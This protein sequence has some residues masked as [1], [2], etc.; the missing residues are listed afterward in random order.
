MSEN[1]NAPQ[2]QG[3]REAAAG[4]AGTAYSDD[5]ISLV[6]LW[7]TLVKRRN[8]IAV[9]VVGALALAVTLVIVRPDSYVYS[10]TLEIGHYPSEAADRDLASLD[11]VENALSKLLDGYIPEALRRYFV[12]EEDQS[13]LRVTARNPRGS[14][15]LVI[16]VKGTEDEGESLL[17][18]LRYVSEQL[19]DDHRYLLTI[20]RQQLDAR[21]E[22]ARLELAKYEDERIYR[23]QEQERV[24]AIEIAKLELSELVQ[25]QALVESRVKRLDNVQKLLEQQIAEIRESINIATENRRDA[26]QRVND[27]SAAMT[28]LMID[29]DIQQNRNR[30]ATLDERLHIGLPN[31][32]D[33]L[34]KRLDDILRAQSNMNAEIVARQFELE[35]F[36]IDWER[37][38]E[39]QRQTVRALEARLESARDTRVVT[40][41][42]RSLEPEGPGKAV[43]L[44][45]GV[46]LG[47]MIGI[48]AAFFAEFLKNARTSD[49]A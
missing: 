17:R 14:N 12:E 28:L 18:V 13:R 31:E 33:E 47:L 38:R 35:R 25:Q 45:L 1:Q 42:A 34:Q 6:D 11:S 21:L 20:K 16:E 10:S 39:A 19:I 7:R 40:P 3:R 5:E 30:L 44:A 49:E 43:I 41:P 4:Y 8:V 23:I 29:S 9:S 37:A 36:R 2:Y 15:L 46:I 24:R 26:V 48:F 22:Q 32:F 27:P